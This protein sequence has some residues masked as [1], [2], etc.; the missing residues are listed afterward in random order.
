MPRSPVLPIALA[1]ALALA[2]LPLTATPAQAASSSYSDDAITVVAVIDTGINPYH[3]AFAD[4]ARTDHPSTYISGYPSSADS[5]DL[6][7]DT[8]TY[9]DA[10]EQDK[11]TFKSVEKRTLY[12]IP[13]TRIVGAV[14]TGDSSFTNAAADNV[15][16]LDEDGHG[17]WSAGSVMKGNPS[18][19]L[20]VIEDTQE[21]VA[22]AAEQDWIDVVSMSY[23]SPTGA[24]NTV[25]SPDGVEAAWGHGKLLFAAA[26]NEP[27]PMFA[28]SPSVHPE[29]VS[30]GGAHPDTQAEE[31][32]AS[33]NPD[34]VSD[35]TV[36][37]LPDHQS[38]TG[39]ERVSGTSFATPLAAGSMSA[40]IQTLR[41]RYGDTTEGTSTGLVATPDGDLTNVNL[42]D[43]MNRTAT[44]WHTTSWSPS[45][46]EYIYLTRA[47]VAPAPWLQM[48]WGYVGPNVSEDIADAAD[49]T[50]DPT[51]PDAAVTYMETQYAFRSTQVEPD[52]NTT[53]VFCAVPLVNFGC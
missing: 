37:G 30:V 44:Y 5:L 2:G 53:E 27:S 34:V 15:P 8:G 12:W 23:G 40:A 50:T 25:D 29:V 24:F 46:G 18:A 33:K 52:V 26:G 10:V 43:A 19:L 42:R 1:L 28:Q 41:D 20:V 48:G 21:A 32:I 16:I 14:D 38:L 51:K 39:R 9:E 31:G 6:S 45:D 17:T 49:G 4:S 3:D 13:G 36:D 11:S 47:P 22:W 7:L 35:F